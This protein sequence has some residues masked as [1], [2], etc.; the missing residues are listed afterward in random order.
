MVKKDDRIGLFMIAVTLMV[1]AAIGMLLLVSHKNTR[2]QDVRAHGASLTRV[3]S[4]IPFSQ[5]I[6]VPGKQGVLQALRYAQEDADFAYGIVTDSKGR[7][8]EQVKT[9][10]VTLPN[11]SGL[12]ERSNWLT[13]TELTL[14]NGPQVIEY[15]APLL[16]DGD[17]AG[18]LSLAYLRPTLVNLSSSQYSLLA[19]LALLVFLLTTAFYLLIRREVRPLNQANE[20]LHDIVKEGSLKPVE[21]TASGELG[22]FMHNF[23]TF[24]KVAQKQ[25]G[26]LQGEQTQLL[27][28]QKVLSYN[29]SRIESAMNAIPEGVLILDPAGEITYANSRIESVLGASVETVMTKHPSQ[30]CSD[31]QVLN[32]LSK[33]RAGNQQPSFLTDTMLFSPSAAQEKNIAMKAFPLFLPNQA[34]ETFGT[35]VV[36]HDVTQDVEAD[37]TRGEFIAHVAHE[38]KTPLNTLNMY[39]QLLMVG[40]DSEIS[41]TEAANVILDETERMSGLIGNLLNITKLEMGDIALD[42]QHTKLRDLLEDTFQSVTRHDRGKQIHFDLNLPQDITP[43]AVDKELLRVAI[44][45][46]LT[47]AIK[48][49]DEGGTVSL[50]AEENDSAITIRVRDYGLGISLADQARIFDKFYRSES[51]AVRQRVGHGLGLALAQSVVQLHNGT[52]SVESEP[53]EGSEFIIS[54]W[55]GTTDVRQAI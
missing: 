48:Y 32:F 33:H 34:N 5:Y 15:Q 28:Q 13:D 11:R 8:L 30:W 29:N 50:T 17:V 23:N 2:E 35:L 18:Y 55:K 54:L 31:L 45:N 38:L 19:T 51:D 39:A 1:I 27:T 16:Q 52:L 43:I 53:G 3:A 22:Q 4:G 46:L 24:V 14:G 12:V 20:R 37:R 44:S 21:V 26:S 42:R 36:F 40:D 25:I 49:S 41:Q 10:G 7:V 6:S 47:N 9:P